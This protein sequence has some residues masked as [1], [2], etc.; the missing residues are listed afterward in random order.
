MLRS[1]YSG[2]SGMKNFQTKLDVIGNNIANVNTSGFKKGR[3]TFQDMM[4]QMTS[5]AQAPTATRGGVNPAQVGLGSQLGSIDNIHTQGF[6]QTTN[7]PLDFALEGDG[8]FIVRDGDSTYYTRAGNFYLDEDGAIVNPQGYYLQGFQGSPVLESTSITAQDSTGQNIEIE[9]DLTTGEII[10]RYN[11]GASKEVRLAPDAANKVITFN[12]GGGQP[13]EVNLTNSPQTVITVGTGATAE[14]ITFEDLDSSTFKVPGYAPNLSFQL[15]DD[16]TF[17]FGN[18]ANSVTSTAGSQNLTFTDGA[19]TFNVTFD[20]TTL[21]IANGGN[22][23]TLEFGGST[24]MGFAGPL[25]KLTIPDDA[26]SFSVQSNGVVNYVDVNGDTQVAGQIAL[27]SFSNPAGLEKAGSNLFLNSTNAGL[28]T[29][30][31]GAPIYV[32][33]ETNG[34]ASIVA[35]A[36]EMSNVDL[37][38]EFTEMI[39]AQRGFQA[40]TRIITTSDEI[41]QELVNLK[42]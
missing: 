26:Q 41:L 39:T 24:G 14:V 40:N 5:G 16:G 12:D 38:E 10:V 3:V 17:T 34:A 6:R 11:D 8:M 28:L 36:L 1:M 29:D 35:G 13:V 23:T 7:N 42:R 31:N 33:P 32:S 22:T 19:T 2:I 27:A 30:G 18:G 4:S 21:S 20:G 25:G 9:N 15:N 37:S